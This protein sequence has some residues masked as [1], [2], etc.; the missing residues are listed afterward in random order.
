[1]YSNKKIN[2]LGHLKKRR[3]KQFLIF[4]LIAFIF[5]IFSKL[6]N[7]YKQ[8]IKLKVSLA[9]TEEEIVLD[10]YSTNFIDAYVEAKVFSLVP[11]IFKNSTD[12]ILDAK[13]DVI[14]NYNQFIFDVQKHK[15][16]IE[17]QLGK[18]YKI[19]S[20]QPDTLFLN[21]S[22]S[23]SKYVPINL[24]SAIEYAIGYDL[25]GNFS[26]NVDSVKVV[27]PSSVVE[28]IKSLSTEKLELK[29]VQKDISEKIGFSIKDYSNVEVFP[30]AISVSGKVTRFTEGTIQIP[31][32]ISNKPNNIE[33]NFFPKTVTVVY[34][35]D[36][37]EFNSI[38]A[39]DF[40][41]ECDYSEVLDN[42]TYLVPK[43]VKKPEHVKR[44]SIKQ[45]RI[46]FI[47]L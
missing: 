45:K 14:S 39:K 12:I 8:T 10:N 29:N 30:K 23:A 32:T 16:L 28:N 41:V 20:L 24:N 35:V 26:F 2:I 15:F 42:Q 36:L 5:L 40:M 33:I 9:N 4:F 44:S 17:G 43:V 21:Y 11:F 1:M 7:D 27:G 22:K 46:D 6:S 47:K 25:K 13:T 34:Y 18:S 38:K 19:L 31:I 3:V 37:D